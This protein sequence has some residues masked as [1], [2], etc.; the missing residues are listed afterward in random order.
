MKTKIQMI[1]AKFYLDENGEP[2]I[3]LFGRY[4]SGLTNQEINDYLRARAGT[5]QVKTLRKK[6]NKIAGVNTGS[7]A[8][9]ENCG[10]LQSL[11][12]RHDVK[13]F[14]DVLFGITNGTYFD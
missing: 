6:F 7:S 11:M 3:N 2:E 5:V 4:R 14:A 9:C 12:Y 1:K 8:S 10:Y 13:R